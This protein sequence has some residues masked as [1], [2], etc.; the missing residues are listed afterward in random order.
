MLVKSTY[1]FV[2]KPTEAD[3]DFIIE[4]V[5]LEDVIEMDELDGGN[6]KEALHETPDIFNNAYVWEKDGKVMCI[7]GVNPLKEHD[8]V[9]VIWM[10]ATKFFDEH[11]MAFIHACKE[12]V[13][14]MID[15]Y[16]YVFNYVY[17]ENRKS[18]K[19]LKWLG[20]DV[21]D[22]EPIGHKGANFHRFEMLNV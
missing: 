16:E 17:S 4:N 10:L 19:W 2:R 7:F 3:I 8:G 20:F 1:Q 18:I 14:D 6:V 15:K 21:K 12:V 5:R 11:S 22:P 13:A 9:G